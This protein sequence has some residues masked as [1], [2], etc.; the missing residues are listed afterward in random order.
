MRQ[1]V[2]DAFTDHVFSGNPAAVCIMDSW[3]ADGKMLDIARENNLPETAF[4]VKEGGKYRLRWFTTAGEV[5][6]C[7]HATLAAACALMTFVEPEKT[8]LV[9]ATRSGDLPVIRRGGLFEL[10]LPAYALTQVPVTREM[11]DAMM[12]LPIWETV[13]YVYSMTRRQYARC[14]STQKRAGHCRAACCM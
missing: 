2:I 9:F 1:Y 3:P 6:L 4:A 11:V 8:E 7:G 14:G 13:C 5:N 12:P 10:D